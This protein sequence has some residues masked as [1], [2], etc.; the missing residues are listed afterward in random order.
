LIRPFSFNVAFD[1]ASAAASSTA[2]AEFMYLLV[3]L[4][5]LCP[6]KLAIVGSLQTRGRLASV[7]QANQASAC[8]PTFCPP[9]T[10]YTL[11]LAIPSLFGDFPRT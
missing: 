2:S 11:A 1:T 5:V 7:S 9:N 4:C 8:S 6:S 10:R 3:M